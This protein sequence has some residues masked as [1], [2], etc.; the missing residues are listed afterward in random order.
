MTRRRLKPGDR[1][2]YTGPRVDIGG[3]NTGAT[4][5]V[6]QVADSVDMA[7][8]HWDAVE[9][10]AETYKELRWLTLSGSGTAGHYRRSAPQ[11]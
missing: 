4:G 5:V 11:P 2:V 10:H 9:V 8:V 7:R 1:V 3:V 6:E